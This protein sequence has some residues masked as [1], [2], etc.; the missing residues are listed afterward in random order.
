MSSENLETIFKPESIAVIGVSNRDGSGADALFK[1]LTNGG[2]RGKIY[3]VDPKFDELFE[4]KI[5]K[6]VSEIDEDDIDLA[7]IN[8]PIEKV[9]SIIRECSEKGIKGVM[10]TSA[11]INGTGKKWGRIKENIIS[12]ARRGGIRVIGPE[13]RSFFIPHLGINASFSST[14]P[15]KGNLA[16]ISQG[17]TL[18]STIMD[19]ACNDKVGFSHIVSLGDMAD[20]D[21]GDVIN[22][23][24]D[25]NKV[26][27]ILLYVESLTDVKKFVGA[28]RS[29]SR[30]KPI[31]ALKAGN[32]RLGK[33]SARY[34]SETLTNEDDVYSSLFRRV[35]IVRVD[36][37]QELFNAASSLSK[38][39][40]PP[41]QDIAI[42]TNS[43]STSLMITD[44]IA[45]KREVELA[46]L[47]EETIK[48]LEL[49]LPEYNKIQNPI[50][51]GLEATPSMYSRTLEVF[52]GAKEVGGV[53]IIFTPQAVTRASDVATA[54]SEILQSNTKPVFAVWMCGDIVDEARDILNAAGIP[55]FRIPEEAIEAFTNMYSYTYNLRLLQETPKHIEGMFEKKRAESVIKSLLMEKE[56]EIPS[57]LESKTI[58][59]SYDIPVNHTEIV[60]TSWE[61]TKASKDIGFPV[62]LKIHS[63]NIMHKSN[64]GGLTLNLKSESEVFDAFKRIISNVKRFRQDAKILGVSV[65]PM[66]KESGFECVLSAKKDP[67]FGPIIFFGAGGMMT[68][69]INDVATAIPPLNSTLA[70]RLLEKTRIFNLLSKGFCSIPPAN[71]DELVKVIVNFSELIAD[72]PEISEVDI[73]PLYVRGDSILALDTRIKVTRTVE[74]SP[75]HL[76]ITPYPSN[77]ESYHT[78]EDGTVVLLRP[79]KPED[80]PLILELFNT[81]SEE[82]IIARFFHLRKITTHE[83]LVRFTQVDYDRESAI[84]AVCQPPGRERILGIGQVIFEPK[85]DKAEYAVVVGDPWQ[86]RGLGNKLMDACISI[87]KAKG[88]KLLWGEIIPENEHM[89]KLASKMGFA[90]KQREDSMYTELEL[91]G[92]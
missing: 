49:K 68:E 87:S 35:G 57:D 45:K 89:K 6:S 25:D 44:A 43:A 20:V 9:P 75:Q 17:G 29:V 88:V 82:T 85:E 27:S 16:F 74:K 51:L 91:N 90:I 53:I 63:P 76:I 38:Q 1:N 34:I 52:L 55:T 66:I 83:Q 60:T 62:V 13:S 77:Y 73:N 50:N 86:G 7:I 48:E 4:Q 39:P 19:W 37:L 28:A 14:A 80:E 5:Y 54:I 70:V 47:R 79:I 36:T 33:W 72:F 24:G 12:E 22:Y 3:A 42:I 64:I 21:F 11:I 56:S 41:N 26:R 18:S 8:K 2:F 15:P 67:D 32:K 30:V 46:T 78:L 81:F 71:I 61:A 84:I 59:S 23:L 69:F 58:I 31:I 40:R 92:S 10:V 65:Q